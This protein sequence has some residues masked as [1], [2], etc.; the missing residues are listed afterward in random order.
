MSAER[1][2]SKR[3]ERATMIGI[4]DDH[5]IRFEYPLTW[6]LEVSDD[7]PRTTVAVQE[8]GA[9]VCALAPVAEPRP[10]PPELADEALAAM[11][12]E[13]P[14]LDAA[15]ALETIAGHRA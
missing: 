6:E 14:A 8:P 5:G 13:Y 2:G 10:A 7:G 11:R 1:L 12:E 4:Y 15:P 9:P 3:S